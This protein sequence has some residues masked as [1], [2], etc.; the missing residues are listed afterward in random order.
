MGLEVPTLL[1]IMMGTE[2]ATTGTVTLPKRVGILRQNIEDF[3][4]IKV[5]DVV[6]MGNQRLW[7]T[8]EERDNL[9]EAEM[10]DAIGI[11]LGELEEIIADE[12]DCR[13]QC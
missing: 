5:I 3:H 7:K 4:Q 8:F 1:R 13:I 2:E 11:R 12:D 6:I 9:Y 10:T